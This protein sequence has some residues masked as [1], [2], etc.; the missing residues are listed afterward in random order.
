MI[1][2]LYRLVRDRLAPPPPPPRGPT[3]AERAEYERR[4]AEIEMHRRLAAAL[5][6]QTQHGRAAQARCRS[7][8]HYLDGPPHA[9]PAVEEWLRDLTEEERVDLLDLSPEDAERVMLGVTVRKLV[10]LR[11]PDF[12]ALRRLERDADG[13]VR[14]VQRVGLA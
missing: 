10:F 2:A 9:D 4:A 7:I 5:R 13:A 12:L 14:L 1:T 3:E 8:H 6:R 11:D